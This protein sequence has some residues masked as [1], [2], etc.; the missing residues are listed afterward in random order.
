MN[1]LASTGETADPCAVPRSRAASVPSG[2]CTAAASHRCTYKMTQGRR[3]CACTALRIRSHRTL[4]KNFSTSR[5]ITQP[6]SQQFSRH[7]ATASRAL[8]PG[9][10]PNEPGWNTG[11]AAAPIRAATTVCATLSA[12]V[13]TPSILVPGP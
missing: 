6:Y 10:Y 9:R 5:S 3:T 2:I 8:R 12:T 4:S 13:G 7:A 1:R 11:S